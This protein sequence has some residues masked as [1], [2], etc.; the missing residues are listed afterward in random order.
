[1]NIPEKDSGAVIRQRGFTL[2]EAMVSLFVTVIVLLGVLGLFDFSN[3]LTRVQTNVADMQ[4]SLRVAQ[5]D[6]VRLI[7]MAGRGGLP[8][9]PTIPAQAWD[10]GWAVDVRNNVPEGSQIGGGGTPEIVPGSDV[11]TVRGV[12]GSIYQVNSADGASFDYIP[13]GA[14]TVVIKDTTPTGIPQDLTPLREAIAENRPVAILLVSPA[15]AAVFATVALD[16]AASTPA[17]NQVTVG[18]SFG[19]AYGDF[20][21][22][23]PG[24]YPPDLTNVG[25][26]GILEERRFYVRREFAVPDDETSDLTPKLAEAR[27]YPGTETPEGGNA[28]NWRLDIADNVF[29]LQLAL[30]FS[31]TV[32]GNCGAAPLPE[33]VVNCETADGE[34]D[35]WLFNGEAN[36]D[37]DAFRAANLLYIRLNTFARTDRRDKNYVAPRLVRTEDNR[38][39]GSPFNEDVERMYRRRML[40]TLIDLRNL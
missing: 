27:V 35:D 38:Y 36:P 23:G 21:S 24:V 31:R 26:V 4:Q 19:G 16:P 7:R 8:M 3:K 15:N 17:A 18:F 22:S 28:G 14:S 40:R 20:S 2:V 30:G 5:S 6:A 9:P 37:P 29:D 12:F 34:T 33:E 39:D 10:L 32:V 25:L 13:G 11:L 1:M